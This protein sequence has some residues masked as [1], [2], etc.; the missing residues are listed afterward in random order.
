MGLFGSGLGSGLIEQ[1]DRAIVD[2]ANFHHGAEDSF[3]DSEA[4]IAEFRAVRLVERLGN[5]WACG[6]NKRR[7]P[8]FGG[9]CTQR[10]LRNYQ[11]RT[12]YSAHIEIHVPG[13]VREYPCGA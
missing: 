5:F 3:F 6:M 9:F 13:I 12:V 11:R 7:A 2:E 1:R 4:E 8:P 10:E